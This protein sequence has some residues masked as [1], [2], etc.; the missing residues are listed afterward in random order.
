MSQNAREIAERL[1]QSQVSESVMN[2]TSRIF[3]VL[4]Q[5]ASQLSDP[6]IPIEKRYEVIDSIFPTEVR[7]ILKS[8]CDDNN[9][10]KWDEIAKQYTNIR[11]SNE[12][13]IHVHLRY[14]T[15]PSEKQLMDIQKFVFDKYNNGLSLYV[16]LV[17]QSCMTLCDPMDCN[18]PGSSVHGVLQARILE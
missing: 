17:A 8:L 4:P 1:I 14:V 9:L 6:T 12:R 13:Q 15:R 5:T 18:P 10:K 11:T 7:K 2:S 3:E 16:C